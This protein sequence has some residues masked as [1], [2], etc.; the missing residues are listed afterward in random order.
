[1]LRRLACRV[2]QIASRLEARYHRNPVQVTSRTRDG[3][4]MNLNTADFIQRTIYLT[5]DWDDSVSEIL[6]DRLKPGMTFVDAGVNVGFFS[7]LAAQL[8]G[9]NGRVIAFEPNPA[10]FA[11][12]QA[13]ADLNG[14]SWIDAHR[15][16]LFDKDGS[17]EIF[18]P[19]ANCG[20][21]TMRPGGANGVTI[22]LVRM[23]DVVKGK[24]DLL[25]IDIEGSEVAA[26]RGATSL[27]SRPD[28][29]AVICEVSEY[30]LR[31]MGNSHYELYDMMAKHCYIPTIISPIRR[32]N[33]IKDAVFFQ[34][35]VL[36]T[37][38]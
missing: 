2:P 13:N 32:S 25:K 3:F 9:Q 31:Q 26:L 8:V 27:L 12:L 22:P 15:Q 19:D 17:G 33:L 5:G 10:V 24:V 30:S 16:G 7:M 14:F 29:P 20:A 18:I 4:L 23:D 21:A 28:A 1:M 35:D 11:Q 38:A 34:Y 6:R 36:F 37:K